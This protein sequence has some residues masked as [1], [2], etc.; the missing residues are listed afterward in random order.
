MARRRKRRGRGARDGLGVVLLGLAALGMMGLAFGAGMLRTAPV[1]P[2]TGCRTDQPPGAHTFILVD[3]TDRLSPRHVRRLRAAAEEERARLQRYDRL[4]VAVIDAD[5]PR[6]LRRLFSACDPGDGRSVNPL[7]AN[8][9]QAQGRWEAG[10]A[11]PLDEALRRING[12]GGA[13]W[14]PIVEAVAAAAS[15]P[16][17]GP[18]IARRR[19][20]LSSDLLEHHPDGFSLFREGGTPA[21]F[22]A[23]PAGRDVRLDLR[24]VS[25]RVLTQDH[26]E[27]GERQHAARADFWEPLLDEAG[28]EE[29]SFDPSL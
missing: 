27:R 4:T 23:T 1:D 26:P 8:P 12:G 11:G 15:E 13:N 5:D 7:V 16:D 6:E 25:V 18:G 2:E 20:L 14:S 10:F 28:A 29:I 24:G 21:D 9:A 17:F 19:L 22:R 3:A